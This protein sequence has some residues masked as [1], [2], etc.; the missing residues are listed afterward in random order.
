M[1]AIKSVF[2]S[3]LISGVVG[4]VSS[5]FTP[6]QI[7]RPTDD[8][9]DIELVEEN[10]VKLSTFNN[11]IAIVGVVGGYHAGKSFLLNSLINLWISDDIRLNDQVTD[12]FFFQNT[13]LDMFTVAEKVSPQ[14]MGIWLME[15]N[16]TLK[17]GSTVFF[18]DTEG[19]FGNDVSE[20]YDAKIF[21]SATLLSSYLVY[22]SIKLIDQSAVDY[23]EILSRRTQLFQVKNIIRSASNDEL[24]GQ[25]DQI[26][27]NKMLQY[28]DFPPLSWVVKDFAQDLGNMSPKQW[29]DQYL[30][31][32]RDQVKQSDD[33]S[34][35]LDLFSR[36]IECH[37]MFLPSTDRNQLK[38]LG[39]VEMNN[40]TQHY[41]DDLKKLK[42]YISNHLTVKQIEGQ[43]INGDGL[44]SLVRFIIQFINRDQYPKVP[45]I[46]NYW[47]KELT[48][49]AHQDVTN[50]Y[51]ERMERIIMVVPPLNF[52]ELKE[53]HQFIRD[54]SIRYYHDML[55]NNKN[56]YSQGEKIVKKSLDSQINT[57]SSKNNE[58]IRQ[59][60][61]EEIKIFIIQMNTDVSSLVNKLPIDPKIIEKNTNNAFMKWVS[62]F[63]HNFSKYENQLIFEET[64]QKFLD[65]IDYE[66]KE[67]IIKNNDFVNKILTNAFESCTNNFV[68]HTKYINVLPRIL[69]DITNILKSGVIKC[70]NGIELFL[71]N[72]I[73][74]ESII[75][76]KEMKIYNKFQQSVIQKINSLEDIIKRRNV[77][78]IENSLVKF[79]S[80]MIDDATKKHL[81]F[82]PFPDLEENIKEKG[83]K[84]NQEKIKEFVTTFSK[85]S[86]Y[87]V[88][89]YKKHIDT[90]KINMNKLIKTSINRNI[91][92]VKSKSYYALEKA[93]DILQSTRCTFCL[94]N[95]I[96]QFY[97]WKATNIG[98]K[99]MSEDSSAK[100]F[101][102][103]LRK[104]AVQV[105]INTD[106]A[107]EINK[108]NIKMLILIISIIIISSIYLYV[109]GSYKC[110]FCKILIDDNKVNIC[111][112]CKQAYIC[113]KCFSDY[114][115][116]III[117]ENNIKCFNCHR[118]IMNLNFNR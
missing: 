74:K 88:P 3:L 52:T 56:L 63:N 89:V 39:I 49:Q 50:F 25:I 100:N 27:K 57:F 72:K 22:S 6:I 51:K 30:R 94:E 54:Q 67:I 70:Q 60:I 26:A 90:L 112:E 48:E 14:T 12:S 81:Q 33:S 9:Q 21:T 77:E 38:N 35:L 59:Y 42:N 83:E 103:N 85:F 91:N 109:R 101:P 36:G 41:I 87:P 107:G 64:K 4:G 115:K 47:V 2:I 40:L 99:C 65:Q 37:T 110:G 98:E 53:R 15:T 31:G 23:L 105:W 24:S 118:M 28:N 76:I 19:F 16:I 93:K 68:E 5:T 17:D 80:K 55:F 106:L 111:P 61:L 102:E 20:S 10:L 66:Y 34:T 92:E 97:I 1:F 75:W 29:L 78:L 104:K 44:S 46:W 62:K 84:I 7:I 11:T 58:N 86:D 82:N 69:P 116:K 117:P 18:M 113:G 71:T 73:S 43:L 79:S 96:T 13:E 114:Y 108:L 32:K 45:S 8:H 95:I